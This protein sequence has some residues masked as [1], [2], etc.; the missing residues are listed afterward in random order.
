MDETQKFFDNEVYQVSSFIS[1]FQSKT[2]RNHH[3]SGTLQFVINSGRS[4]TFA[5]PSV[6]IKNP[7][8]EN[9]KIVA[10]KQM[11]MTFHS[12]DVVKKSINYRQ[13]CDSL[14]R[15]LSVCG[16]LSR[17]LAK[18]QPIYH[19]RRLSSEDTTFLG[20]VQKPLCFRLAKR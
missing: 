12:Y 17:Q 5:I 2:P 19:S 10:K 14:C 20:P 15:L 7:F 1:D 16:V 18:M 8:V 9:E 3:N 4:D 6:F 11:I 13:K